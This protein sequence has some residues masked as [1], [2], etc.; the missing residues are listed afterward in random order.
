MKAAEFED[1]L[2]KLQKKN[3]NNLKIYETGKKMKQ[4]IKC[5]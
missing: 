2:K 1:S 4:Q 3:L 5:K